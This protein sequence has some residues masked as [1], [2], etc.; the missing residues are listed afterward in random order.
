MK[1][2]RLNKKIKKLENKIKK[3]KQKRDQLKVV[4]YGVQSEIDIMKLKEFAEKFKK[5]LETEIEREARIK[6][7]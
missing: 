2:K 1:L 3:L 6:R 7:K 4:R 5:E